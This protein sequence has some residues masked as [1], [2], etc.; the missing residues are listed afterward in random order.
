MANIS[1]SDAPCKALASFYRVRVAK[2]YLQASRVRRQAVRVGRRRGLHGYPR[3]LPAYISSTVPLEEC[4]T[5]PRAEPD[6]PLQK[7]RFV[8]ISRLEAG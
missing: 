1:L 8:P 6:V 3:R 2:K 7:R 4:P 5:P